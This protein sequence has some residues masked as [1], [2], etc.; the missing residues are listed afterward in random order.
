MNDPFEKVDRWLNDRRIERSQNTLDKDPV[1]ALVIHE[2]VAV[3]GPVSPSEVLRASGFEERRTFSLLRN[4]CAV[5][6]IEIV[7]MDNGIPP[8]RVNGHLAPALGYA[9]KRSD[10]DVVDPT[11]LPQASIDCNYL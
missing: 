5:G 10:G 3:L 11:P 2:C 9:I 1:G 8:V 4:L 6:A 7:V